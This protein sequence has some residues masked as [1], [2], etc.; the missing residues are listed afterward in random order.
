VVYTDR[1]SGRSRQRQRRAIGQP[2]V[3][4]AKNR[5][6]VVKNIISV[7]QREM[8][9]FSLDPQLGTAITH[10]ASYRPDFIKDK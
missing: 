10:S 1:V 3:T 5:I 9:A 2:V 6:Y 8:G 4:Y 7:D